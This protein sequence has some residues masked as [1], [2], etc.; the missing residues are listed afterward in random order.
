MRAV[1]RWWWGVVLVAACVA[2]ADGEDAPPET[3]RY[4]RPAGDKF[5]TECE[6]VIARDGSGWRITSRTDRG[7]TM[8]VVE[9]RYDSE[10]RLTGARAQLTGGSAKVVTVKVEDGRAR[11]ERADAAAAEFNVP[12]GTIVTSAPDWSDA[13]QLCRRYD[14]TRKGK[15]EF[16]ALWIHPGQPA[17]RLT[18]SVEWEGADRVERDGKAVEL[19]RYRIRIRDGSAYAAWA[20][21]EGVLVRLVPLPSKRTAP[22]FTREGYEK[23]AAGLQPTDR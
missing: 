1:I 10:D 12:K 11:V 17:R 3:V 2:L 19:G 9:T 13:F 5:V 14:R 4:V 23:A 18:F 20:D 8:M 16:P 7:A 15:Q 21:A 22:G 6:F